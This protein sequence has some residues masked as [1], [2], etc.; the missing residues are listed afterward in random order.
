MLTVLAEVVAFLRDLRTFHMW[1]SGR[2]GR[3]SRRFSLSFDVP[4]HSDSWRTVRGRAHGRR[5]IPATGAEWMKS[6][7]ACV[8][9]H[10]NAHQA[11]YNGRIH[12]ESSHRSRGKFAIFGHHHLRGG[13]VNCTSSDASAVSKTNGPAMVAGPWIFYLAPGASMQAGYMLHRNAVRNALAYGVGPSS[14]GTSLPSPGKG[15][16]RSSGCVSSRTFLG[17]LFTLRFSS[18]CTPSFP[19]L[20]RSRSP[21]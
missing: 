9:F 7:E 6:S 11:S 19:A 1:P 17:T 13:I 12:I 16:L 14:C 15:H 20:A 2:V 3:T 8:R 21:S 18:T 5:P 4:L 10:N